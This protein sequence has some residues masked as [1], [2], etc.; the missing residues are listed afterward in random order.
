MNNGCSRDAMIIRALD[1]HKPTNKVA[2]FAVPLL[3][4]GLGTGLREGC[5]SR[6]ENSLHR[7][8]T[9][10]LKIPQGSTQTLSR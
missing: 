5:A 4:R 6:L 8:L 1:F 9:L 3:R 2:V 7:A 10:E